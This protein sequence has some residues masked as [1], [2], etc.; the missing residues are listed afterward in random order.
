MGGGGSSTDAAVDGQ[1]ADAARTVPEAGPVADVEVERAP[2]DVPPAAIALPFA[3]DAYFVPTGYMGDGVRPGAIVVE[4]SGCKLPRPTAARG[5]CYKITYRPQPPTTPPAWAGVYWLSPQDNWG[6]K[7]GRRIQPGATTVAFYAAGATGTESVTFR[8]GGVQNGT[9][10]YQ[11]TFR[12]EQTF[13]LTTS[14]TPYSLDLTGQVYDAVIGGFAWMVVTFDAASWAPGAP[15]IVFYI[16][17]IE[18]PR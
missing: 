18:W 6:Q 3:V 16:D 1:V 13:S 10:A 15:P 9:F 12:V 11:D 4:T 2:E 5:N 14:L 7:P 8:A 17:D